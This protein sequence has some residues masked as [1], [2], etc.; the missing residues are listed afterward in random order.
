VVVAIFSLSLPAVLQA[1]TDINHPPLI[2]SQAVTSIV[3]GET[4]NY[5]V[6]A[7]DSDGQTASWRLT[8][9]PENMTLAQSTVTW[10][11]TKVGTYN[12]VIEAADQNSGYDTQAWQITVSP[13]AA[14]TIVISPNEK[15]TNVNLGSSQ[16]FSV[17]A[18]DQYQNEVATQGLV[19]SADTAIGTIDKDGTFVANTGGLGSISATL[20]SLKASAGIAVKDIRPSLVAVTNTNS[21]S[22]TNTSNQESSTIVNTATNTNAAVNTN[23]QETLNPATNSNTNAED[24]DKNTEPCTNMAHWLI[25]VIL[26]IYP[27]MLAIYYGYE[28]RHRSGGWWLFPIF[29]TVIGLIIYYKYIC[30]GTY[31]WW[32]WILVGLGIAL[33][34]W[35]KGRRHSDFDSQE[36]L[37]F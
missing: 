8:E 24:V 32:P 26:I 1:Q 20:G 16:K 33:T 9:S 21:S 27:L 34:W 18:Y 30:T 5:V 29:V 35:Y 23:T 15:P 36:K 11:P 7:T 37:P 13:A 28:K 17:L 2:T 31:L 10:Q 25:I 19:W 22:N 4:Y 6:A 12:V 14:A 3:A